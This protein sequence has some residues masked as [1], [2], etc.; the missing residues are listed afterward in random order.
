MNRHIAGQLARVNFI[1]GLNSID[2]IR[3]KIRYFV[4]NLFAA[5]GKFD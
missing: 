4:V 3:L 5:K 2:R 1:V